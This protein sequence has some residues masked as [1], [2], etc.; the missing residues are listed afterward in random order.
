MSATG[1][2]QLTLNIMGAVLDLKELIVQGKLIIKI[3]F[4]LLCSTPYG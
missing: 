4:G 1:P 3:I 2:Q